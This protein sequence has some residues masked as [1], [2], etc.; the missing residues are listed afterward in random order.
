ML[1]LPERPAQV[2]TLLNPEA[3]R[4]ERIYPDLPR[5]PQQCITCGGTGTFRWW[6]HYAQVNEKAPVVADY[7][8]PC[9]DQWIM[10]R[11]MLYC[12]IQL[13]YQRLTWHDA[14]AVEPEARR[15]AYEYLDGVDRYVAVG[16]GLILHGRVGTGKTLLAALL[17]KGLL[18]R[19]YDVHF[20]TFAGMLDALT[21]GWRDPE[22]RVWF[23][24]RI[25]NAGFLVLDD[26]GREHKQRTMVKGEGLVEHTTAL[27]ESSIDELLR[28]R[29]ASAKP[30]IVT[31]N[32]TLDDLEHRYGGNVMSLL[33]ERSATYGF[34]GEDFRDQSRI[35]TLDEVKQG[36]TRPVVLE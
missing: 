6:D 8:C 36:L 23:A 17:A 20:T 5:S 29:V 32:L 31:T 9:I 21:A 18:A 14:V 3:E 27:S 10:H 15:T 28:Y 24:K 33:R 19:G 11:R 7:K 30:T 2:A 12:G 4:L 22:E 16:V 25:R 34:A 26:V 35:R 13:S 1:E